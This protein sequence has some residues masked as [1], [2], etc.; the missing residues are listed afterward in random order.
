[1]ISY[2]TYFVHLFDTQRN[3]DATSLILLDRAKTV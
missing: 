3:F 2:T 1:M